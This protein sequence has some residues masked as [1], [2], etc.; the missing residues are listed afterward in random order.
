MGTCWLSDIRRHSEGVVPVG[1]SF[2]N[3]ED[4]QGKVSGQ[5]MT[6]SSPLSSPA[7]ASSPLVVTAQRFRQAPAS[8][9]LTASQPRHDFYLFVADGTTFSFSKML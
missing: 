9:D 6:R 2:E 8:G 5:E 1:F 3:A 4:I 7:L